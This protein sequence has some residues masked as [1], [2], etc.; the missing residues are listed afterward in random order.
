MDLATLAGLIVGGACL[1]LGIFMRGVS[2][3]TLRAFLNAPALLIVMGGTLAAVFIS[4]PARA[5]AGAWRVALVALFHRPRDLDFLIDEMVGYAEIARREGILALEGAIDS[6][7]DEFL[8]RALALAV[9]GTS[10]EEIREILSA[11]MQKLQER[12]AAGSRVFE[13]LAKYSPA[14]GMI[15]TLIGL[16]LMLSYV[17]YPKE[18]VRGMGIALVTTFYGVVLANFFFGPVAEKLKERSEEEIT[19]KQLML[20]GILAIQ[21]GDNPRVVR[22]KLRSFLPSRLRRAELW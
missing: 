22:E 11:E 3:E 15:G 8:A 1:F 7:G 17:D 5:L 21:S 10:P 9:D 6:A 20:R 18:V 13:A 16:I 19:Q 12:H 4:V 2:A 14:W